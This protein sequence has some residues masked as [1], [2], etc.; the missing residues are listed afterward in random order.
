MLQIYILGAGAFG[1]ALAFQASKSGNDIFIYSRDSE[2][3]EFINTNHKHPTFCEDI[4]LPHNIRAISSLENIKKA[5][6]IFSVVPAQC[7]RELFEKLEL[8]PKIPFVLCSKGV[9]E[10]ETHLLSELFYKS[11]GFDCDILSG[12]SFAKEMMEEKDCSLVFGSSHGERYPLVRDIFPCINLEYSDDVKGIDLAG[13][14]K[15]VIAIGAGFITAKGLGENMRAAFISKGLQDAA[16]LVDVMGGKIETLLTVAGI[17]DTLLTAT[18]KSSRNFALGYDLATGN[19]SSFV[20]PSKDFGGQA[21]L[22]NKSS[23]LAEGKYTVKSLLNKAR[24]LNLE[25]KTLEAINHFL[26]D[27]GDSEENINWFKRAIK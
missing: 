9:E 23:K 25:L 15:N 26:Y 1:T 18:S 12:P 16:K 4:L 13:S 6:I 17:G 10:G 7:T 24:S 2:K 19:Q 22:Y 20:F 5:D 3:A 8:N 11:K 27:P 21:E 14:Y